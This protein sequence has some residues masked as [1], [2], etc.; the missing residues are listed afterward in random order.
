[1]GTTADKL[2]RLVE[3]KQ[4]IVDAVNSKANT[5]LTINSKLS[6]IASVIGNIIGSGGV[7]ISDATAN[8]N[9]ILKGKTAYTADGKV[10]G[11]IE[12]YNGAMTEG[13]EQIST[14]LPIE[15]DSLPSSGTAVPNSG[16]VENVYI[17]T[18]LSVEEVVSIIESANLTY[19]NDYIYIVCSN[20][21]G[22]NAIM[23][24]NYGNG[25]VAIADSTMSNIYFSSD[26]N[27]NGWNSTLKELG[28]IP[29]DITCF[30]EVM[31]LPVGLENDKLANL[32]S[33]TPFGGSAGVEGAI[34]KTPSKF[35]DLFI[36]SNYGFGPLS[37]TYNVVGCEEVEAL[38][39]SNIVS[40]TMES[41]Y[42]YYDKSSNDIYV[43]IN[44]GHGD[45]WVDV[46]TLIQQAM[47]F[48]LT[49]KGT[50]V[51]KSDFAKAE[52]G[53]YAQYS[54]D[55]YYICLNGKFVKIEN[56]QKT[57]E[58]FL[59][60]EKI[61]RLEFDYVSNDS[62]GFDRKFYDTNIEYIKA[63]ITEE[64][65]FD[66]YFNVGFS[67]FDSS[68][69]KTIY[70]NALCDAILKLNDDTFCRTES[71][72][73]LVL[74]FN[75]FSPIVTNSDPFAMSAIAN[76]TGYIYVPDNKVDYVKSL[77]GWS[78]HASQIRP[79]SEYVE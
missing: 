44:I 18:S 11:T 79:L 14:G 27:D 67:A 20:E 19:Q 22:S 43:Y 39:T 55:K 77:S 4:A 3:G 68:R 2:Q 31:G 26:P 35:I 1:M 33:T 58:K 71:L 45:M 62:R 29:L 52:D 47:G 46:G 53:Y 65:L 40:S 72:T 64:A 6:N 78:T 8:V 63:N 24:A 17:N 59:N 75:D 15:V 49:F 7:N 9:D 38:P 54:G 48:A 41:F 36:A 50:G 21:D 74:N 28:V 5:S 66:G 34:Y 56:E 60:E 76:G 30:S 10:E 51:Y 57:L 70:L 61:E 25:V 23:V 69:V 32:F 73:K 37:E 16:M 42:F 13:A 12:T